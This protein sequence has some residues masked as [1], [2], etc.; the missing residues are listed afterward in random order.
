MQLAVHEAQEL[1]ELTMSCVNSITNMACFINQ[2]QDPEL[3]ALL[4]K[5][6][7]LHIRDYNIKVE[8]LS[9]V[10]GASM[11]LPVP[12]L[13]PVL[14]S[15]IS[16]STTLQPVMPRTSV[17]QFNDREIGTAYLLTLK[18]AGRE[19]AWAAMEMSNPD[20]RSFLEKA[21]QMSSHHAYDVWQWMVKKGYY[22]LEA[23]SPTTLVAL[24]GFYNKVQEPAMM[25]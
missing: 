8:F 23:A 15:F 5:H 13:N 4:Q 16:P 3:Q 10:E 22:P 7:P 2:A 19:Y 1:N 20:I 24:G 11:A 6:F 21:F 14:P 18:R 25:Q 9:Q 17:Q 12:D